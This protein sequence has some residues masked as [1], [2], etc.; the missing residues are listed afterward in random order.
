[1]NPLRLRPLSDLHLEFQDYTPAPEVE[2]VTVLAGDIH[3]RDRGVKWA[4]D[5]FKGPVIYVPGN[6]EGY[7]T[8]WQNNLAK[9][10]ALAQGTHVHVL[11]QDVVV[12]EGVR[13]VGAT[14]W[15]TFQIWPNVPEAMHEA[16]RGRNFYDRGANDYRL[17]RTGGYRKLQPKDT[18]QWAHNAK[19]WLLVT[20]AKPHD[21]PTVVVTHHAPSVRSL[22]AGRAIDPLDATDANPWDDLV[23]QSG[24]CLWIHGHTH[25]PVD[26]RIGNT[27]VISNPR[28]YPSQE[29]AHLPDLVLAV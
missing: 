4:L 20:L 17:I 9:M 7:G 15:A 19:R 3:T 18:A 28:G 10:K 1:M 14:A 25:H 11:N 2:G 26:Y 13:F 8:H 16:G 6:H 22:E 5:R 29:L 12:V 24:A 23:E 27:R 21:G